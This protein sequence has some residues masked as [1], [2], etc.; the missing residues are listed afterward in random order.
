MIAQCSPRSFSLFYFCFVCADC[1]KRVPSEG[2]QR[3]LQHDQSVW[4]PRTC[5]QRTW[6]L[7][8][9]ACFPRMSSSCFRPTCRQQTLCLGLK[10]TRT[11]SSTPGLYEA[12]AMVMPKIRKTHRNRRQLMLVMFHRAPRQQRLEHRHL[13]IRFL[14]H[15]RR[16]HLRH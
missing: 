16:R 13:R 14:R 11:M 3:A 5:R 1:L 15:L 10:K 9:P 12:F 2:R 6:P 4:S 7:S 8:T